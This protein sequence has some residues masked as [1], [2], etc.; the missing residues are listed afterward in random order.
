M[1]TIQ[2]EDRT[3]NTSDLNYEKAMEYAKSM[4]GYSNLAR[5][6][7]AITKRLATLDKKSV[8]QQYAPP[9]PETEPIK[10]ELIKPIVEEPV[11]RK[12]GRPRKE[13]SNEI[14]L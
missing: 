4:T 3:M 9:E 11:K 5:C 6:Y 2:E 1:T 14:D 12:P 7:V 8:V 13:D 10:S